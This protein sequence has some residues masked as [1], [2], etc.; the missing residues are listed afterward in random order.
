M[1]WPLPPAFPATTINK[2]TLRKIDQSVVQHIP[3]AEQV[4]LEET[5]I[6]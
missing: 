3:S 4:S 6:L 1:S 2:A 5:S